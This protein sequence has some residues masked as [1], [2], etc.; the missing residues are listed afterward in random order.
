MMA[1]V[2][3]HDCIGRFWMSARRRWW[4]DFLCW[5]TGHV[6]WRILGSAVTNPSGSLDLY[7]TICNRCGKGG[8]VEGD[9]RHEKAAQ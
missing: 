9:Y 4:V 2:P 6:L 3:Q 5:S 8:Y 1:F 7:A